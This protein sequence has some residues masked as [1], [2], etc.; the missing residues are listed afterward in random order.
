MSNN[1]RRNMNEWAARGI[2]SK[3]SKRRQDTKGSR[4][5]G[6]LATEICKSDKRDFK[7]KE[8]QVDKTQKGYAEAQTT[9]QSTQTVAPFVTH[10]KE[11]LQASINVQNPNGNALVPSFLSEQQIRNHRLATI[12]EELTVLCNPQE[13]YSSSETT[14]DQLVAWTRLPTCCEK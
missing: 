14:G 6:G 10:L 1:E 12:A 7:F 13:K 3:H 8:P 2:K 4:I 5:D 9:D 11:V